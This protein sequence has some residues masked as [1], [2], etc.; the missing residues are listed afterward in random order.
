MVRG[1][2]RRRELMAHRYPL[3]GLKLGLA[4]TLAMLESRVNS[5]ST[6][7]AKDR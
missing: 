3:T 2:F 4:V 6:P 1:H 7:L 5:V